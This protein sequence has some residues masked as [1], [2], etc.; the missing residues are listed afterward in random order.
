[1]RGL[2]MKKFHAIYEEGFPRPS[3]FASRGNN[4]M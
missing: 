4:N 1:M 3:Y 2:E